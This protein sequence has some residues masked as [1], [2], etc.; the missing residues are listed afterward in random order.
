M[1]EGQL[2]IAAGSDA[3]AGVVGRRY[4]LRWVVGVPVAVA[5]AC[6][7]LAV[8]TSRGSSG[9]PDSVATSSAVQGLLSGVPQHGF[10]LGRSSAPVTVNEYADLQCPYCDAFAVAVFPKLLS[11]YVKPGKVKFVFHNFPFLGPDSVT[12]AEAAIAAARQGFAWQ[13]IEAFYYRQRRENSGYV[14][15]SFLRTVASSVPGLA[16]AP[17]IAA[18]RSPSTRAALTGQFEEGGA[19]G[20]K[21]TPTFVITGPGHAPI[22]VVG[23]YPLAPQI[24]Q[25]LGGVRS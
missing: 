8:L 15:G 6:L 17:L 21:G 23:F 5:V 19:A 24:D 12:A 1:T 18:T 11:N 25:A 16:L 14:T 20:V 3:G 7:A 10:I 13:F 9:A 4:P 22:R 2:D